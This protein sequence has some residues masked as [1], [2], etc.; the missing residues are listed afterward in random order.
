M[1]ILTVLLLVV[2][3]LCSLFMLPFVADLRPVMGADAMGLVGVFAVMG[4]RW[5]SLAAAIGLAVARG[6]LEWAG[7]T[8]RVRA[9][10]AFSL[11]AGAGLA[12]AGAIVVGT[13]P[14]SASVVGWAW[15]LSVLVPA[16]LMVALA[17]DVW[18]NE[19]P[20][21][22]VA[23]WRWGAAALAAI[24]VV[25]G[26]VLW[27][28][29]RARQ[30]EVDAHLQAQASAA[31]REDEAR[32]AAL[33]AMSPDA[34]L[35]DWLP[36]L[37]VTDSRLLT[38]ALAAVRARPR[39]TAE[40]ADMLRGPQAVRA[41][42]FLWL[43]MPEARPEL[44]A[45]VRDALATLPAWA[46]RWLDTH[47]AGPEGTLPAGTDAFPPRRVIDLSSGCESA[48]VVAE[49]YDA[50]QPG[51]RDPLNELLTTLEARALPEDRY[52]EDPT[53]QCRGYLRHWFE[54]HAR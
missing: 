35:G 42:R 34:P 30:A 13:G 53:Y 41:L 24:V 19:H 54:S 12:S 17:S 31:A 11:H 33:S 14:D 28:T 29:D 22:A 39:L 43:W 45:P 18:R 27:T 26:G 16:T 51:L 48:V 8:R 36:W 7:R 40:L 9:A 20:A 10:I 52:A 4:L 32:L 37:D 44:A 2:A 1:K 21:Q 5:I 6:R 15:V 3:A 38:P 23:P 25:G 46:G 50:L 49:A 47:H